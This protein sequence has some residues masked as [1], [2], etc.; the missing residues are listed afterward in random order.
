MMGLNTS[1][2]L[3][4]YPG[5]GSSLGSAV[6]SSSVIPLNVWTHIAC[7]Y[8][9]IYLRP[10]INGLGEGSLAYSSTPGDNVNPLEIGYRGG[11]NQG[12]SGWIDEVR[13]SS[14]DRHFDELAEAYRSGRDH[15]L[16]RTIP[17][18]DLSAKNKLPFYIAADRP[19]SYMEATIGNNNYV[20]YETDSNTVGL[21]HLDEQYLSYQNAAP[22]VFTYTGLDQNYLV[23]PGITSLQT[24]MWA[25][26]GGG[27]SHGGWSYG[28]VGGAGGFSS[29][30]VS[31][32]PN[33]LLNFM[34]GGGGQRGNPA[35]SSNTYGGGGY[36]CNSDCQYSASGGGRS[37]IR[38]NSADL[39]TAG[40]GGGG[41]S[42]T[43]YYGNEIGGAGGGLT[44]QNGGS[45]QGCQ[46]TAGTQS[47]G[48]AGGT[49]SYSGSGGSGYLSGA[50]IISGIT[51]VGSSSTPGYPLDAD[52]GSVGNGGAVNTNGNNGMVI[53]S[54]NVP[55][56][57][58]S[59]GNNR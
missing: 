46:G 48:G 51:L 49:C 47:A 57:R 30:I 32:S 5:N 2:Q 41:G 50:G 18:T 56:I 23:P 22:M 3:L 52:R 54:Y 34:V 42:T 35:G 6:T 19:G 12:F 44:G 25:G 17:S 14:N 36:S 13:I 53:V 38:Y 43:A 59:S 20:N 16:S 4:C 37:A 21:W 55:L 8:D 33:Q 7:V 29:G 58:D 11:S 28:Y 26:G 39:I 40:G 15:T 1:G 10:F 24:K 27:G 31:T 9:S 45:G